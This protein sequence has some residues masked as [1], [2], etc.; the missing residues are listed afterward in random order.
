[1]ISPK[2]PTLNRPIAPTDEELK[3]AP[4]S[5]LDQ[6][7]CESFMPRALFVNAQTKTPE[8]PEKSDIKVE[9]KA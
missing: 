9:P 4:V 3:Y 6:L 1:M 7:S 5:L 2:V 8:K